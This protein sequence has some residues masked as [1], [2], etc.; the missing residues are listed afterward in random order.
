MPGET[1]K[2][3]RSQPR[4]PQDPKP[5]EPASPDPNQ[6]G[7]NAVEHEPDPKAQPIPDGKRKYVRRSPYTAGNE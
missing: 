3:S 7:T 4:A 5:A 6:R 1:M 2:T